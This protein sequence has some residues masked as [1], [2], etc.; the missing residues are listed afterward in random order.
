MTR[1]VLNLTNLEKTLNTILIVM[2][3]VLVVFIA[4]TMRVAE[5]YVDTTGIKI[6]VYEPPEVSTREDNAE[7]QNTEVQQP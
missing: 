1:K 4:M 3:C 5:R 7:S 6:I 2:L